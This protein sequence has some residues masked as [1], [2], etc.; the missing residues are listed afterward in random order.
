MEPALYLLPCSL[1]EAPFAAILPARN[2]EIIAGLRHFI[3]EEVRTARRFL[4]QAVPDIDINAL[5]FYEMG[6]Y[7]DT[8]RFPEYL[9]PLSGGEPMGMISEAGCPAVADPGSAIVALCHRRGL[10]VVPLVGPNSMIL[11]VMASGLC[12]QSFAFHGYL[13]VKPDERR[14]ALKRL[15]ADSALHAQ[16]Q[17][18]IETPYRN[19]K[20]LADI[21]ATCAPS[22]QLCV[23]AGLTTPQEFVSTRT[24]GEWKKQPAPP[25]DKVPAVFA[26]L[27]PRAAGRKRR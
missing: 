21:L 3:V 23:A 14:Q 27:A 16:T 11:T 8:S 7:A 4:K 15:E 2:L 26:L 9:C 13:P 24:V 25:I 20:F 19:G 10:R 22:T 18:F 5:T 6:K 17:L 1:G 12:G